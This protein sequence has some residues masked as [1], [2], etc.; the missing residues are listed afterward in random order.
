MSSMLTKDEM[1][2]TTQEMIEHSIFYIGECSEYDNAVEVLELLKEVVKGNQEKAKE[3][4]YNVLSPVIHDVPTF[5]DFVSEK[6]LPFINSIIEKWY[7]SK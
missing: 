7:L 1:D 6:D 5:L 3:Y 2:F 4:W